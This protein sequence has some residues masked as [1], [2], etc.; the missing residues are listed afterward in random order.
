MRS[1][2]FLE[3]VDYVMCTHLHVDH[4]GRNTRLLDGRWVPMFPNAKFVSKAEYE[5]LRGAAGKEGINL[6]I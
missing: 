2:V 6:V 4:C 5:H 1:L 3:S